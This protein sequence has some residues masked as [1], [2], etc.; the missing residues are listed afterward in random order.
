[1]NWTPSQFSPNCQPNLIKFCRNITVGTH[2]FNQS[3]GKAKTR[4]GDRKTSVK[5][6]NEKNNSDATYTSLLSGMH[7]T[8]GISQLFGGETESLLR[9]FRLK[10]AVKTSTVAEQLV[11]LQAE[12]T[13]LSGRGE[14]RQR[15]FV[16]VFLLLFFLAFL[17]LSSQ[18]FLSL[19]ISYISVP[20]ELFLYKL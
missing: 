9:H 17:A 12:A 19:I 10:K 11:N 14:W 1:M 13:L 3:S 7:R 8:N 2:K 18:H 20:H 16:A 5:N 6:Y 4:T 15:S